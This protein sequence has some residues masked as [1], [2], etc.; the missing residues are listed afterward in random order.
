MSTPLNSQQFALS[1][2]PVEPNDDQ[3]DEPLLEPTDIVCS[4]PVYLQDFETEEI[5]NTRD[6]VEPF[7]LFQEDGT[8]LFSGAS[9][10]TES[11]LKEFDGIC[12]KHKLSKNSRQDFLKLFSKAL[13]VRNNLFSKLAVLF[14]PD[15]VTTVFGDA[16][17]CTVD[18]RTQ[19][20]KILAKN[21][22]KIV[23]SWSQNCSWAT[24]WD[25][26][27]P[28]EVQ[29]VLNVDGAPVFKSSKL[30][31]WP[32]WVQIFNLPP[33]L[34]SAF[35]NLMLLGLWH[36]KSKPDFKKLLPALVFELESLRDANFFIEGV[37][38]IKF[39]VRSIVADMPATACVLCM[40]QFNG[41]SSCPHCYIN[42]FSSNRRMLFSCK[43]LFK[44]R[45]NLDFKACGWYADRTN[46]M[47][48]GVKSSTPL[49]SLMSLPWDCPIDPMH[50][51]FLGTGKVLTKMMISLL[52]GETLMAAENLIKNLKVPFDV[53]HKPKVLSELSFWKAFDFKWFFFHSGPL[54]FRQLPVPK[55]F[56]HS[57]CLLSVAVRLL[58][59]IIIEDTKI[60]CAENLIHDFFQ[61]IVELYD[62]KSQS[63][64]F[65]TIRHLGEQVR[66]NGPLWL[67]SAFCFES[68]NHNLLSAV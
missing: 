59:D 53:K 56:V 68:A 33:K 21:S 28:N 18:I 60:E 32:I 38:P 3:T 49:N 64:N 4:T 12:D 7:A 37:G 25:Q 19:M 43:K 13:P 39:R 31:V 47:K 17:F 61:N 11:F 23:M 27:K 34:R 58:S 51:I 6:S 1:M 26:I 45:E 24:R 46:E 16:K 63:F 14:L 52:K 41:Y 35:S 44:L 67:F 22:A 15:I 62:E 65:H 8:P 36:G 40:I 9:S 42:G 2:S 54:I 50:Q 30:S 29:I 57:F 55:R 66:R 20:E 48:C 5:E 10:T